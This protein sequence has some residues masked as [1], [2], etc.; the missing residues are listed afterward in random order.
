[1]ER[2]EKKLAAVKAAY[3]DPKR[4][5]LKAK[6]FEINVDHRH[7]QQRPSRERFMSDTIV[8]AR[9]YSA[10]E[11][12]RT[13]PTRLGKPSQSDP[14]VTPLQAFRAKNDAFYNKTLKENRRHGLFAILAKMRE[15]PPQERD[16]IP[17][18]CFEHPDDGDLRA[19]LGPV[20]EISDDADPYSTWDTKR[21][22]VSLDLRRW[23]RPD[24]DSHQA[25]PRCL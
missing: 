3:V 15:G 4:Y 22:F 5:K 13:G 8:N 10:L 23:F 2:L 11:T 6:H 18:D 16:S 24:Y 21:G 20:E 1:M 19:V 12:L 17:C 7:P 25:R 9:V 14:N